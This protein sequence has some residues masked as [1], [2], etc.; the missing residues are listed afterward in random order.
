MHK[1][2]QSERNGNNNETERMQFLKRNAITEC[3]IILLQDFDAE[4]LPF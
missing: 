1:P 4:A 3:H 2:A